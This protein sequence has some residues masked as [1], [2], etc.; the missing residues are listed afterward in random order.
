[1]CSHPGCRKS[2][3][4]PSALKRHIR[5]HTGE[6]PFECTYPMCKL[7]FAERGNLKVRTKWMCREGEKG[8]KRWERER[9]RVIYIYIEREREGYIYKERERETERERERETERE[10]ERQ[11]EWLTYLDTPTHTHT[12][13]HSATH[14]FIQE[15]SHMLVHSHHV[16]VDSHVWVTYFN[17]CEHNIEVRNRS[18]SKKTIQTNT[19]HRHLSY[20]PRMFL[21]LW[22]P[23]CLYLL[24]SLLDRLYND[25]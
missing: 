8:R 20:Q 18:Q 10:G 3:A 6:K 12:H 4:K 24:L 17:I 13:I 23:L 11:E 19:P 7:R 22:W 1:M 25:G 9:E 5:T 14:V 2:F 15:R 21:L 16:A